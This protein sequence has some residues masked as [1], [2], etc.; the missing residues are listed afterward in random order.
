MILCALAQIAT[1]M[2]G[3]VDLY[4]CDVRCLS[5][6][7]LVFGSLSGRILDADV[8]THSTG[9]VSSD[10][11]FEPSLCEPTDIPRSGLAL[12]QGQFGPLLAGGFLAISGG[13]LLLCSLPHDAGQKQK[14][15]KRWVMQSSSQ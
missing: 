12:L 10:V 1:T 2:Q 11:S 7:F 14:R 9:G 5:L 15:P 4:R 8:S 3:L 13:A 6:S